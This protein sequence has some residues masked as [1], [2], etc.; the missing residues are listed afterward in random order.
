[1]SNA[2]NRDLRSAALLVAAEATM[3]RAI[4]TAK[5]AAPARP[6]L[7]LPPRPTVSAAVAQTTIDRAAEVLRAEDRRL[8]RLA[9]RRAMELARQGRDSERRAVLRARGLLCDDR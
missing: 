3:I 2:A 4:D 1:M 5:P 9:W 8:D 7:S 6:R